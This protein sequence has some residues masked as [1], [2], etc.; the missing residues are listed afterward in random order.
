[1]ITRTAIHKNIDDHLTKMGY[2]DTINIQDGAIV[3]SIQIKNGRICQTT[4][5]R[6]FLIEANKQ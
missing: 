4:K 3:L 6:E 2:G 1:M 5:E